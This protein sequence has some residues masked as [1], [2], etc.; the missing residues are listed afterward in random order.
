[1]IGELDRW[2]VGR[3][4]QWLCESPH[5]V[6]GLELCS[7]NLSGQSLDDKEL[8]RFLERAIPASGVPPERLCFEVTETAAISNLCAAA[9]LMGSLRSLGCRFALDDFG[10]GL[11]SFAYL[12][13]LP[14]DFLKIDGFFVKDIADDPIDH[15]MVKSIN[16]I[17]HVMGKRTVAEFVDSRAILK[18]LGEIGVDYAQGY[19]IGEPSPIDNLL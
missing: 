1:L 5:V 14:V 15:A 16:D 3:T 8:L 17:G 19:V 10:S 6:E 12:K 11:S 18:V 2:V 7:I 9:S 4:L 13:T